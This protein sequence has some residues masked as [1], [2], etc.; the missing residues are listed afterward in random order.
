VNGLTDRQTTLVIIPKNAN[1]LKELSFSRNCLI[2]AFSLGVLC[3]TAVPYVVYDYFRLKLATPS[4]NVLERQV[5]NQRAQIQVFAR[6]I[7]TLKTDMIALQDFE[8]KIRVVAN[9]GHPAGQDAVFGIGGSMPEDMDPSL[10]L[11]ERHNGLLR[12]MHDQVEE[13]HEASTIQKNAFGELHEYLQGQKSL[14]ASTPTIRPT[15]GWTSCRFGHRTSPFTGVKEFHQGIDIAT[16]TGTPIVAPA[17][18]VIAFAG[19]KGRLGKAMVI[20]HENGILTRYG[21]LSKY[22][23]KP[24]DRVKRGEQIALV[25]NTGRS[26]APHLH[27]EVKLNGLPVNPNKYILD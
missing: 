18:G 26:T 9:I 1:W 16:R 15:T 5:A 22:L 19:N 23:V 11:T 24:G 3:F 8:K 4:V 20:D 7:D 21:H 17:N 14:L 12:E 10:S 13:I 2:L 27:Y 6:K 25:G